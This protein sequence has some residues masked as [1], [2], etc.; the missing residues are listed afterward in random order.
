MAETYEPIAT[1]TASGSTNSISFTSIPNTYTDLFV[2][3][4]VLGSAADFDL[5]INNDSGS[6]YSVVR[7]YADGTT[8]AA[9]RAVNQTSIQLTLGGANPG[10]HLL[11]FNNYSNTTT[12]KPMLQ[13]LNLTSHTGIAAGLYRSTSA[14]NRLDFIAQSSNNIQANSTFTIYGIKAA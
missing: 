9:N 7:L 6:N 11:N 10:V 1:Q 5:R 8:K 3:I 4:R 14:I 12:F 2:V 13:R